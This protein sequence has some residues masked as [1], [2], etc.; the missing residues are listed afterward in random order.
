MLLANS[1]RHSILQHFRA[2]LFA[3]RTVEQFS[4]VRAAKPR[5]IRGATGSLEGE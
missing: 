1:S 2:K 3:K 4:L 5:A